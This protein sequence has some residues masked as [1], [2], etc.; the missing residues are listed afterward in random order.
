MVEVYS[1]P[2]PRKYRWRLNG[3][4]ISPSDTNFVIEPPITSGNT[5][6]FN[7]TIINARCVH[8]HPIYVEIKFRQFHHL[9]SY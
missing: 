3:G 8:I 9:L 6:S 4:D 2:S 7:L 1:H 5:S